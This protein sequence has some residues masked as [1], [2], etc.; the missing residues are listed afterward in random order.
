MHVP[1]VGERYKT[2]KG[3]RFV[4]S[5]K[6]KEESGKIKYELMDDRNKTSWWY[7]TG[8]KR[9][10]TVLEEYY[11]EEKLS[12]ERDYLAENAFEDT[13]HYLVFWNRKYQHYKGGIYTAKYIKEFGRY[14]KIYARFVVYDDEN[15]NEWMRD[16]VSWTEMVPDPIIEDEVPRY[17]ELPLVETPLTTQTALLQTKFNEER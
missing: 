17:K 5:A 11:T 10:F 2:P 16:V 4:V 6:V 9:R 8:E 15:G 1:A 13:K 7:H 3:E 12:I 14:G